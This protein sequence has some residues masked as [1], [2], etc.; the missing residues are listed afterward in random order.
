[1][2]PYNV[3]LPLYVVAYWHHILNDYYFGI[4]KA[5][6]MHSSEPPE[7]V[8]RAMKLETHVTQWSVVSAEKIHLARV[9]VGTWLAVSARGCHNRGA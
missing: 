3:H 6:M 9:P 2:A 4:R 5:E 7:K 8:G 1:M